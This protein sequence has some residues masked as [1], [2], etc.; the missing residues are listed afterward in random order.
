MAFARR[1]ADCAAAASHL[2]TAALVSRIRQEADALVS[3]AREDAAVNQVRDVL[4]GS[5]YPSVCCAALI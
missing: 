1:E 4:F 3:A 5:I 2:E